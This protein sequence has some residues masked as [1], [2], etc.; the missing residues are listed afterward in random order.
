MTVRVTIVGGEK[1]RTGERDEKADFAS[2]HEAA[3]W[4]MQKCS[5]GELRA[6]RS[7]KIGSLIREAKTKEA[8]RA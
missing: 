2:P 5:P 3:L 8:V 7:G 1:L 4:L 6:I